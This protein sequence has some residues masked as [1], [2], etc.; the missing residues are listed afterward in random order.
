MPIYLCVISD[1][2]GSSSRSG[3]TEDSPA[4]ATKERKLI[5]QQ[6]IVNY[7]PS[8]ISWYTRRNGE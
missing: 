1:R 5:Q 8:I 2:V 7:Q 3:M 4:D 6:R